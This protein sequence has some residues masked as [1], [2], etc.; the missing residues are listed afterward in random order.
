MALAAGM[1][2]CGTPGAPQPPSLNLPDRVTDLA[3]TRTGD[4]VSLTWTMPK[5]NTDRLLLKGNIGLS[6]C[7]K[8]NAGPCQPVSSGLPLMPGAKGTFSEDLPPALASGEPRAISYFVE[9]KNRKGRSAGL[10]N[11]AAVLAGK[12]PDAVASLRC[13][14][15]KQG[16]VLRWS[17]ETGNEAV[18]LHRTLLTPA[19]TAPQSERGP[20]TPPRE[21][22]EQNLLVAGGAQSGGALDKTVRVGETYEFRAQHVAR[23][24]VNGQTMEL[25][26]PLSAPVRAEILDVFPPAVPE[27]LA[28]VATQPEPGAGNAQPSIDLSWQPVTDPDLA[29]YVIYRREGDSP[30]QRVSPAQPVVGPAFHDAQVAPG[31]TYTYAVSAVDQGGHESARSAEARET[32]PARDR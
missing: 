10:S 3:A 1:T 23:V 4:T 29:G 22:P 15:R 18:R 25:D 7:R 8:E 19:R 27:G 6:V 28:A 2:G 13:D 9:L 30:W 20:L 11:A 21:L 12:A 17:A 5:R 24:T 26:G 14:V 31:H 32:V 16:V